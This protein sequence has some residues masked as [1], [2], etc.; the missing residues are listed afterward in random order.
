M[1]ILK[2]D[3]E[4]KIRRAVNNCID[5]GYKRNG[6]KYE[7]GVIDA[8][9]WIL[10]DKAD[11][12]FQYVNSDYINRL[13]S[14]IINKGKNMKTL[15]E[16]HI[17]INYLQNLIDENNKKYGTSFSVGGAY[18][19]Y[20]LWAKNKTGGDER[21]DSGSRQDIYNTFIKYR[22]S[23]KYGFKTST[24]LES[25]KRKKFMKTLKEEDGLTSKMDTEITS[26]KAVATGE[27]TPDVTPSYMDT[28]TAPIAD[29][30]A[31]G[32]RFEISD[33]SKI[34]Q[35]V[36]IVK[37]II[38]R[39]FFNQQKTTL[40]FQFDIDVKLHQVAFD[41]S[42]NDNQLEEEP[43]EHLERIADDITS[44]VNNYFKGSVDVAR[45]IKQLTTTTDTSI[46]NYGRTAM[47][48]TVT[49]KLT[50]K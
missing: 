21:L 28:S 45:E 3:D 7:H 36:K 13:E 39:Q 38:D 26:Q 18:G 27:K 40:S 48:I 9:E 25:L 24:Q 14:K 6:K 4:Q 19:N 23:D 15:K 8:L 43:L 37:D 22:F 16:A 33:N 2:Y 44:K 49:E 1:V 50:D 46:Q 10:G 12:D 11:E 34:Y 47:R 5:S 30:Y 20:E 32:Q 41:I 31:T 42:I 17:S 29:I 35:C